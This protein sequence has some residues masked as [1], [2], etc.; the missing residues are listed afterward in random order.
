MKNINF[1][2]KN[3]KKVLN[4]MNF[5]KKEISILNMKNKLINVLDVRLFN[6][7]HLEFEN[8]YR[9]QKI[10]RNQIIILAGDIF[11]QGGKQEINSVFSDFVKDILSKGAI[12]LFVAG[13]H[14][15]WGSRIEKFNKI[16]KDFEKDNENFYF[17]N[18]ESI[19]IN[20]IEFLGGT[21]WTDFNK[22]DILTY[23]EIG[24]S[25]SYGVTANSSKDYKKIKSKKVVD[26]IENYGKLTTKDAFLLH[27]NTLKYIKSRIGKHHTQFVITHFPP[28]EKFLN[29]ERFINEKKNGYNYD[30]A[31]Y[32]YY[33]ELESIAENF[34]YWASGHTHKYLDEYSNGVR[35]L[36][37]PRGYIDKKDPKE[38]VKLFKS[39][40]I[41]KVINLKYTKIL[42][43]KNKKAN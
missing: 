17:L 29:K 30:I 10:K 22:G 37:N 43:N 20:D 16:L 34:N 4:L 7:L 12:V 8:S 38:Q 3:K 5:V 9:I 35:Y 23:L 6:D 21:L 11:C 1:D 40:Q 15:Y 32:A 33:S 13:N 41:I 26:G 18:D 39:N 31:K 24:G 25:K 19:F 28:S 42:I 36:S 2:E 27:K 14:E